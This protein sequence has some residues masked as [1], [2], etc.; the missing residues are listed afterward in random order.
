M[1]KQ[2]FC[3]M[4]CKTTPFQ[5]L[6]PLIHPNFLQPFSLDP[7]HP[8]LC[9]TTRSNLCKKQLSI[10]PEHLP[11]RCTTICVST[12]MGQSFKTCTIW[13]CVICL[14][15]MPLISWSKSHSSNVLHRGLSRICLTCNCKEGDGERL[16]FVGNS[17]PLNIHLASSM[18]SF[19]AQLKAHVFLTAP[20]V[21]IS[22]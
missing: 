21:I 15:S 13:A 14:T 19:K 18:S 10:H 9:P 5:S 12:P 16:Q 6:Q 11:P 22:T 17:L 1:H 2:L 8:H 4:A 20:S 7:R 3:R